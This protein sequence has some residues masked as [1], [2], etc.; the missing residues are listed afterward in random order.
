MNELAKLLHQ[1]GFV[2]LFGCAL[3]TRGAPRL[4]QW[5]QKVRRKRDS[6]RGSANLQKSEEFVAGHP[7]C[8]Y[9]NDIESGE[10]GP[11]ARALPNLS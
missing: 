10:S 6:V 7:L 11:R 3:P 5:Q 9:L 8:A 4:C 1:E 2:R